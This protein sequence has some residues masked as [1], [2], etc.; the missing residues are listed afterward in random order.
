MESCWIFRFILQFLVSPI[1]MA[2]HVT[3]NQKTALFLQLS[4]LVF[5]LGVVWVASRFAL[6]SV[7]E[8]Y[9]ISGFVFYSIYLLVV[10]QTIKNLGLK[11]D[12]SKNHNA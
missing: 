4:G 11:N 3:G 8:A 9:A 7:S 6:N 12:F 2:L 10:L 5:R 1:S